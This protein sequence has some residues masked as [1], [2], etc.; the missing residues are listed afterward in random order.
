MTPRAR[1]AQ[2]ILKNRRSSEAGDSSPRKGKRTPQKKKGKNAPPKKSNVER[3]LCPGTMQHSWE[4]TRP[5][6]AWVGWESV[7]GSGGGG[8]PKKRHNEKNR[9]PSWSRPSRPRSVR[10]GRFHERSP[11]SHARTTSSGTRSP[12][13]TT[14]SRSCAKTSL[15]GWSSLPQRC[16]WSRTA[17]SAWSPSQ[18]SSLRSSYGGSHAH[19]G[20]FPPPSLPPHPRAPCLE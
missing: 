19:A 7:V 13:T 14:S 5:Y 3:A 15:S 16:S 11:S 9:V 2:C 18:T 6:Q 12:T 20:L 10:L 8:N 1:C 17:S 4:L